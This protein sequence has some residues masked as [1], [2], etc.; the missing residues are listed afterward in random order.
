MA[1]KTWSY[2]V[3]YVDPDDLLTKTPAKRGEL[4]LDPIKATSVQRAVSIAKK[5]VMETH[6]LDSVRDV[7]VLDIVREESP[8]VA[9]WNE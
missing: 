7:I 1:N 6:N 8:L 4:E 5:T 9:E 2:L 3:C